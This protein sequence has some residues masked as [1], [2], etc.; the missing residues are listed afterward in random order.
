MKKL[1]ALKEIK[2]WLQLRTH[3][4]EA[5]TLSPVDKNWFKTLVDKNWVKNSESYAYALN[6]TQMYEF[7]D[8]NFD[9]LEKLSKMF[10]TKNINIGDK[11]SRA[12]CETCDYGSSYS[13]TIY[14]KN[15]KITLD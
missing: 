7:V 10:E 2:T 4:G 8:I 3:D 11:E 14:I 12:G 9:F 5:V 15:S 1:D 6:I 13:L